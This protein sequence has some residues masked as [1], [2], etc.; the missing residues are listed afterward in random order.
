VADGECVMRS[1][2]DQSCD[3][4]V[5]GGG[6]VGLA[7]ARAAAHAGLDVLI[8]DREAP[9]QAVSNVFDGRVSSIARGSANMLNHLGVWDLI[10][11][12]AQPIKEIRVTDDGSPFFLHYASRDVGNGPMGYILENRILRRALQAAVEQD[13]RIAWRTQIEVEEIECGIYGVCAQLSDGST[14]NSPLVAAADGR[15]SALRTKAGINVINRSYGQVGIVCTVAHSLPHGAIAHERF[16]SAGPFAILPM[17][18]NRSSLV[19]TERPEVA[20]TILKLGT[21]D[22]LGE[23]AWRFGDFLGQLKV[24]SPRWQYPL[25]LTM[26]ERLI[27]GRLALVGD[28][29]HAIHPIAGQGLN[30]GLRDAAALAEVVSN[31]YQLGMDIGEATVLEN[32]G[33]WR[34]FDGLAMAAVTDSLNRLFSNDIVP[35]REIRSIG[36][37]TVNKLPILKAIFQRHAM[38]VLGHLPKLL[39]DSAI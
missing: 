7:L 12:D 29:A 16:L 25:E 1:I 18:G 11:E 27:A 22:F 10:R 33:R 3:L 30:L 6:L 35:L 21:S 5:V 20:S 38:G 9:K 4:L 2:N 28:A 31:A 19:W 32:Y 13:P 36:L 8:V 17:T 24:V 37:A 23:L 39:Q 14:A 34:R 26:A 15:D